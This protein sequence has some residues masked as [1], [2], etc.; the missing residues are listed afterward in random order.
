MTISNE[1]G[2]YENGNFGIRIENLCVTRKSAT[3][4]N[5]GGKQYLEFE[6][7]TLVPI[8]TN[9]INPNQLTDVELKWVNTYHQKVREALLPGMQKYFP[10]SVEYLIQQT[11]PIHKN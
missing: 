3:P 9:L 11:N 1:P 2:Y 5:F 8:K 7:V 10:E 4:N 6:T